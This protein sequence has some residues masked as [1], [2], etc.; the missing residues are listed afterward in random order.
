[1]NR[2]IGGTFKLIRS[3]GIDSASLCSPADRYDNP[4][5][6]RSLS[7]I[8][9]FKIPALIIKKDPAFWLFL[10][11]ARPPS[12]REDTIDKTSTCHPARRKTQRKIREAGFMTV[13]AGG[14]DGGACSKTAKGVTFFAIFIP[15]ILY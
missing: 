12:P 7:P 4:I 5:P 9:C 14:G 15:V 11:L 3:P 2:N 13:L 8:D 10:D 1:V 6:I